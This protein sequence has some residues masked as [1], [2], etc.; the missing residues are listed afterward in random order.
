MDLL[1]TLLQDMR[2]RAQILYIGGV[3]G[4]WA[5]DTSGRGHVTFHLVTKGNAWLATKEMK[6]PLKLSAGDL[7]LFPR[8]TPH[9]L[10]G[11][12]NGGR[13][14]PALR[15]PTCDAETGLICGAFQLDQ[16]PVH[17][18]IS[19]L[20]DQMVLH[21][22]SRGS[23][24]SQIVAAMQRENMDDQPAASAILERLAEAMFIL[25]I[26][27]W[28]QQP[29]PA[30][31][32]AAIADRRLQK[33]LSALHAKLSAPWTL[34]RLASIAGQSRTAF[35]S[36]FRATVGQTPMR[37][38]QAV[39]MRAA[40]EL[41]RTGGATVE[42]VAGQVGYESVAAFVRAFRSVHRT[43]PGRIA[44]SLRSP[45]TP[46]IDARRSRGSIDISHP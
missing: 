26:R 3:C 9:A 13:D 8:D 14:D 7:V 44:R 31:L 38:L 41:L 37:Y 25:A 29:H 27:E 35:A 15:V 17:P 16:R 33:A 5:L 46:S 30:G 19:A 12:R 45:S 28:A 39:R 18:L 6:W 23:Q 11:E 2:P 24:A 1:S 42:R 10:T 34:D 40:H 32:V 36:T 20:P 22:S 21:A 4:P 43:T